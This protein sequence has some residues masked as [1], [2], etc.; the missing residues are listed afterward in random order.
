MKTPF[1]N[2]L[3]LGAILMAP[4]SGSAQ[5][6]PGQQSPDVESSSCTELRDMLSE[7]ASAKDTVLQAVASGMTLIEATVYTMVCGGDAN[8]VAVATAGITLADNL[9]QAHSVA[10]G[11]LAA[12]GKTGPVADAV[13]TALAAYARNVP[14]PNVHQDA[15]TPTGVSPSL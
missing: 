1:L 2:A 5:D 4:L 13:T 15:Y 7:G 14:Q 3:A 11:V 10:N 9:A 6:V 8:R 12:A